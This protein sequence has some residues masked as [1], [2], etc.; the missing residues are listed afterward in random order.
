MHDGFASQTKPDMKTQDIAYRIDGKTYTGYLADGAK[1]GK[2]PGT[3]AGT[4]APLIPPAAREQFIALLKT[5]NA[6][7]KLLV[8]GNAGHSFTD[9]SVDAMDMPDFNYHAPTDKRSWEAMR[10]LF[11]EIWGKI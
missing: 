4:D 11:D 9:K 8:N 7:W 6:D 5:A 3:R 1:G 2:A 10:D